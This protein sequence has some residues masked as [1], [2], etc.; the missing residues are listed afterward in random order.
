MMKSIKLLLLMIVLCGG[1]YPFAMIGV[2]KLFPLKE[3]IAQK[4]ENE[5]YFW[6]RPSAID[7]N[8]LPSGGSNLGPTSKELKAIVDRRRMNYPN[9]DVPSELLFA[10]GSGLDPHI[11]PK[12]A[13][14]QLQRVAKTRKIDPTRLKE[15]VDASIEGRFLGFIGEPCINVLLLNKKLDSLEKK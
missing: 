3:L 15:I 8:P 5:G 10:S 2:A 13:Y 7:Y 14:F 6:S 4:F 11:S 1:I 9:S 12:C